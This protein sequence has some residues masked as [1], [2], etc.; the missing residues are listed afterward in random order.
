[1]ILWLADTL[2]A[3]G[4]KVYEEPGW[5]N[6]QSRPGFDPQAVI[7]HHTATGP[8][9][10][11]GAV[12][13][14]LVVGRPDLPGPLAQC[15]LRRDGTW[16]LIAAGRCNHNGYGRFGN[17]S[18]GVEAYNDGR[19]EPWP[20]V[21]LDSYQR[22]VAAICARM[23]W[24]PGRVLGHRESDPGRKIDPA[25]ID[26]DRFRAAVFAK[27]SQEDDVMTPAEAKMLAEVHAALGLAGSGYENVEHN[28]VGRIDAL[29]DAT[30]VSATARILARLAAIEAKLP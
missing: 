6:R 30:G 24:G 22:G 17:D 2:R 13:R 4:L 9:V 15:G 28:A 27:P 18:I 19:G 5:R 21:Q 26:M 10:A 29:Y 25:G 11:D 23:G 7:C 14:L 20:A 3:A 8:E 12:R 1:M 16:D